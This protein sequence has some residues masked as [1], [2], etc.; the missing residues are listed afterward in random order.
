MNSQ[1]VCGRWWRCGKTQKRLSLQNTHAPP[2]PAPH[3]HVGRSIGFYI[4][5]RC[6]CVRLVRTHASTRLRRNRPKQWTFELA[7]LSLAEILPKKPL[8]PLQKTRYRNG[9]NQNY[10]SFGDFLNKSKWW[11]STLLSRTKRPSKIAIIICCS[12]P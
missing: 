5:S 3:G 8:H 7:S 2:A 11:T 9:Q 4:A 6:W 12:I 10:T 1:L